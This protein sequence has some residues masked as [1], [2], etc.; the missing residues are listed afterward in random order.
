LL[1][2]ILEKSLLMAS[3]REVHCPINI[4]NHRTLLQGKYLSYQAYCTNVVR[5]SR[6]HSSFLRLV[7]RFNLKRDITIR[8]HS[9]P[10]SSNIELTV[11]SKPKRNI[12]L[13]SK[14]PTVDMRWLYPS[15]PGKEPV[16]TSIFDWVKGANGDI[17]G[18]MCNTSC[19]LC[20]STDR[21][22]D[23]KF[24]VKPPSLAR[25]LLHL[26][27]TP[28]RVW[29]CGSGLLPVVIPAQLS[30][31]TAEKRFRNVSS[32][33]FPMHSRILSISSLYRQSDGKADLIGIDPKLLILAE[34]GMH[35]RTTIYPRGVHIVPHAI[36]GTVNASMPITVK[37]FKRKRKNVE[38]G[39]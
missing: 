4:G 20:A 14:L 32:Y 25:P 37:T 13:M 35:K 38:I 24:D 29:M 33:V 1:H 36:H 15:M 30:H 2:Q 39:P 8:S 26:D 6:T 10:E 34:L 7:S 11:T 16:M 12:T 23:K 9:D 21:Y 18:V 28:R 19:L 31:V 27:D 22:H 5:C 3:I 17:G